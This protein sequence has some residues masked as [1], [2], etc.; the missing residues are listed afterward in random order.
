[1]FS[2]SNSNGRWSQWPQKLWHVKL[3]KVV[4]QKHVLAQQMALSNA[5]L[6]GYEWKAKRTFICILL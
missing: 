3:L 2:I 4:C 1:M 6:L 5:V